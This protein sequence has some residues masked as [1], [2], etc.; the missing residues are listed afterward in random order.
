MRNYPKLKRF[1]H[2]DGKFKVA[3][4]IKISGLYSTTHIVRLRSR[5]EVADLLWTIRRAEKYVS[6]LNSSRVFAGFAPYTL[7]WLVSHSYEIYIIDDEDRAKCFRR[8]SACLSRILKTV[9]Y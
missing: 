7:R 8:S 5:D 2:L 9:E 1:G 3:L 4:S 6:D